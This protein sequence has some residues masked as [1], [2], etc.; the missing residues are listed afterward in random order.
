LTIFPYSKLINLASPE[1]IDERALNIPVNGKKL[2]P[3][4]MTENINVAIA[5][6]KTIGCQV[7]NIGAKDLINAAGE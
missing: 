3:W 4:E 7:I 5:S 1:A 2:N 6:A